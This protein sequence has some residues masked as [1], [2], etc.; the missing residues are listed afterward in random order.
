M[1]IQPE[2]IVRQLGKFINNLAKEMN[3]VSNIGIIPDSAGD[4]GRVKAV[5]YSLL[6]PPLASPSVIFTVSGYKNRV[7]IHGNFNASHFKKETAVKFLT[8]LEQNLM[9]LADPAPTPR[10][11]FHMTD[12]PVEAALPADSIKET[13]FG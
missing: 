10:A 6:A 12:L 1:K 3:G 7:T 9:M 5:S 2:L 8:R 4:F 13:G 11:N